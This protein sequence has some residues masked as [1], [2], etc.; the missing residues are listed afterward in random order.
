MPDV[1]KIFEGGEAV[2]LV[3]MVSVFVEF[4]FLFGKV[5]EPNLPG[6]DEGVFL[7]YFIYMLKCSKNQQISIL[8]FI[9]AQF[10]I[11]PP[12]H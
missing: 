3:K 1:G 2:D 11:H 6:V 5:G 12:I 4:L 8:S 9:A 10:I 7:H